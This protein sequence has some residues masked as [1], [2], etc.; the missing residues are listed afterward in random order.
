MHFTGLISR[1]MQLDSAGWHLLCI[2]LW[3]WD[4]LDA[5]AFLKIGLN[6]TAGLML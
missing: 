1:L 2:V 6:P 3:A 4:K 5:L